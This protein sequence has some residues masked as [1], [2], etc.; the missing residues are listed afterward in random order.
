MNRI[1]RLTA[2]LIQLQSRR[3]IRANDIAERFDISL[4]TVYRDIKAL[5]EAGVPI[6]AEAGKGYYILD[7]Y[8]LPPVMF[9][10]EEA[11]ALLIGE[12]FMEKLSDA[13]LTKEYRFALDKVRAILRSTEKEHLENLDKNIYIS[14]Y[15]PFTHEQP[16][17]NALVTIQNALSA[18]KVLEV[19]YLAD[20]SEEYTKC[21]KIEPIALSY[22][23][24]HW[25]LIGYCKMRKGYRDFR[26]DRIKKISITSE[27]VNPE[28]RKDMKSYINNFIESTELTD[29]EIQFPVELKKIISIQKYYHGWIS[30][31]ETEKCIQ[32][33]FFTGS[34]TY[35]T[36]WI[37]GLEAGVKIIR[38][39]E[40]VKSLQEKIKFLENKYIKQ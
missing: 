34:I 7:G 19:D 36:N 3:L 17:P 9:T 37:L 6:G 32:M 27:S 13:S 4:R 28:N 11:S 25:H 26:V 15:S 21:R 38:P 23:S 35:M 29:V 20:Y 18:N 1:D 8:K 14:H 30:E 10:K 33:K 40:L 39:P 12:K 31:E 5:E 22:Y 2:I 16:V 24:L